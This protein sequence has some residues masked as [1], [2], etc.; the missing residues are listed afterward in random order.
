MIAFICGLIV[1]VLLVLALVSTDWLMAVGWRQ[2]L[3]TH[4]IGENA[5][6]PLP[7]NVPNVGPG[8]QKARDTSKYLFQYSLISFYPLVFFYTR[9]MLC[10]A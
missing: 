10:H 9:F 1:I 7:F 3:F 6:T 4:C 8:C 2:G 5:P